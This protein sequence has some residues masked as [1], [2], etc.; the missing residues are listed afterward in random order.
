MDKNKVAKKS[1]EEAA[2]TIANEIKSLAEG[3][4]KLRSGRLNDK[5]LVILLQEAATPVSYG[6][7]TTR[8]VGKPEIRSVLDAL[9]NLDLYFLKK[10][11]LLAKELDKNSPL[12]ELMVDATE[13][14]KSRRAR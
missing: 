11:T 3:V 7:R 5:A 4:R 8:K 2:E 6:F 13:I 12:N 10:K 9:N 14:P 1:M